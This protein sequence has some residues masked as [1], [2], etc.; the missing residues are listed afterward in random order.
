MVVSFI[1]TLIYVQWNIC[2]ICTMEWKCQAYDTFSLQT[3][4]QLLELSLGSVH[5]EQGLGHSLCK[6]F[7]MM[8][9]EENFKI[10]QVQKYM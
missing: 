5:H 3:T 2:N 9:T 4:L 8:D 10:L 1:A 6:N 7:D